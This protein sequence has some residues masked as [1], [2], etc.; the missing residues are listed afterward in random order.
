MDDRRELVRSR[1]VN[2]AEKQR[3]LSEARA[4]V[5][6]LSQKA[7][8]VVRREVHTDRTERLRV[9]M[10]QQEKQFAQARAE[11][12]REENDKRSNSDE[13]ATWVSNQIA[14]STL[15]CTRVLA[16][17]LRDELDVRDATISKLQAHAHRLEAELCKLTARV[18]RAE[19]GNDDAH[20]SKVLDLPNP[21]TRRRG[22]N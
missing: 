6:R 21:L 11:R 5:A 16:E 8:T 15:H 2:D 10:E 18:I 17:T 4:T 1:Q 22:L 20:A 3:I 13:W 14:A 9:A 12:E 19:I 7:E